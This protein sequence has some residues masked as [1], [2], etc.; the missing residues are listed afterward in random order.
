MPYVMFNDILC[1]KGRRHIRNTLL[2]CM[3]IGHLIFDKS[4]NKFK[5]ISK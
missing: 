4:S 2:S 5:N 1:G 3:D